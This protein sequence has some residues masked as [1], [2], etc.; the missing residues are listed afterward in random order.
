VGVKSN[1]WPRLPTPP[2]LEAAIKRRL[3]DVG[4]AEKKNMDIADRGS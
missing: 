1:S 3:L 4:V 2:E